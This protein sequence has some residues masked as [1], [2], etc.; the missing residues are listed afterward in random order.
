MIKTTVRHLKRHRMSVPNTQ[1]PVWTW[2]S[3]PF[4]QTPANETPN[5]GQAFKYNL[6]FPGQI[7]D[8]VMGHQ[9]NYSRDYDPPSLNNP[10]A[11]GS[12]GLSFGAAVGSQI[13]FFGGGKKVKR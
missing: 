12:F 13:T 1:E 9:Y 4:G 8:P 7:Y 10:A 3:T 11:G 2:D 5:S 6:H